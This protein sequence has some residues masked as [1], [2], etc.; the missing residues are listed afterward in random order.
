MT[1][2]LDGTKLLELYACR[3]KRMPL[4]GFENG[5]QVIMEGI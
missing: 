2:E 5:K 3:I 1:L 4:H